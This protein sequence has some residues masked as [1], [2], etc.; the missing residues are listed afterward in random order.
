M[1]RSYKLLVI[2]DSQEILTA[3]DKYLKQKK[4]EVATAADGLEGL[5]LLKSAEGGFDLV[6]TDLVMP[7][8]SG[9]GV[10]AILKKEFPGIPVVA[11][12]GY[13]EQ[14]EALALE[15]NADLVLEKPFDLEDLEQSIANLLSKQIVKDS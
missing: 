14:P 9:V 13:G 5:K 10:I 6:I 15:A 1:N 11:I 4:Y 7:N 12:T 2:D 3:I 8:V